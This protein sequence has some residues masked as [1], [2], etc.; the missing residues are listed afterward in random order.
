MESTVIL[1][2]TKGRPHHLER[3]LRSIEECAPNPRVVVIDQDP[4]AGAER[5]CQ[6]FAGL[7]L[8][9]LFRG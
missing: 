1:V 2:P 8:D 3:C 4:D 5:L 6:G 9:Y 7:A